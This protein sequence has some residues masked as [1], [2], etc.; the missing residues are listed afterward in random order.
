MTYEKE[1][2]KIVEN[3]EARTRGKES[4]IAY[5]ECVSQVTAI[6]FANFTPAQESVIHRFLYDWGTMVRWL[7]RNMNKGWERNTVAKVLE[8]QH[9][10]STFREMRLIDSDLPSLR[11]PIVDTYEAFSPRS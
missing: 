6:Q 5:T 2:R 4:V 10:L 9:Q 7:G 8:H 3:Q 1:I 11:K